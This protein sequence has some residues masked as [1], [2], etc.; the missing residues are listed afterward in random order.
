MRNLA[1]GFRGLGTIL[2]AAALVTA[3]C[4]DDDS[5]ADDAGD[6][7]NET[8][9][10]ADG[11]ADVGPDADADAD[12]DVEVGP[13]ADADGDDGGP[14]P[15]RYNE[16]SPLGTN[17]NGISDWSTEWPFV[18]AFKVSRAWISGEDGGA[19][20]DGRALD[21][22]EHGWLRSLLPGQVARTL[23]FW[24]DGAV[25]PAGR[26][27]VLY[28]GT[29]TMEY[30][31]GA[32]R[33]AGASSP[34]R[35]VLDFDPTAGGI[36]INVTAV[37]PSDPLR[38]IRVLMPGGACSDDP[39]RWCA[40]DGGCA[41]GT[42]V[43]FEDRY[44][45]EP[46]HPTF[47]ERTRTYRVIRF[48]D[49]MATNNSP[50]REWSE[51]AEP[52]DARWSLEAGV[53][54]ETMVD[55]CNRL[56]ADPW[57]TIP[58]QAS[59]DFVRRFATV[60]RDRLAPGLR[61]W[62][63]YSNEV[64]NGIFDQ[65]GWARDRGRAA[66]LGPSDYEAQLQFYSR[67]AVQV[68]ALWE[69]VFGGTDRLVRVMAS[70]AANSWVSEQVLSFEGADGPSDVLAIAPYFGGYLG[71]PD[72]RARVA[73]MTVE[74]L[75]AELAATALPDAVSWMASQA[76]V[77]STF[78]VEL[79]AYEGGQ[80]LAGHS[81]VE[82]DDTINALFD[83]VNRDPRMGELYGDYLDAWRS[84]GG[85]YF[86]HFVNCAGWS[87]WGRWGALEYL[88]QPRAESPKFDALQSFLETNP[89]WW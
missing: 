39:H 82:N 77:A 47:L 10:G 55:L 45:T 21:L 85:R 12:A 81:G 30:W 26:C 46:F 83:A 33:D 34:G 75:A 42:C 20:D 67:R 2:L 29:G 44:P 59:D 43:P 5:V 18:D 15:V 38:N 50:I 7:P 56:Q 48:M 71:G 69:E 84:A 19:W 63:E 32:R 36:G 78:G 22:D 6:V 88:T 4:G 80:H 41:A 3:A 65:A 87:K 16:T 52:D 60:V 76:D 35:D 17:L 11:D 61:A 51:R 68:F 70:Q 13:D 79:V 54:V 53:P 37:D 64:W 58:H 62:V 27:V 86:A 24:D 9:A 73:A 8:E 40:D 14:P 57:F 28:D 66:G 25:A 74:A 31:S 49:W 72:E 23:M 89:R 1:E